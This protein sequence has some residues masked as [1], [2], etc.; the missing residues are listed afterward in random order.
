[1]AGWLKLRLLRMTLQGWLM[2]SRPG[3]A[4]SEAPADANNFIST[5]LE[6]GSVSAICTV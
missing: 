5:E 2:P 3:E 6:Q 1:M 4:L